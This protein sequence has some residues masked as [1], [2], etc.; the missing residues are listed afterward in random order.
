MR[1]LALPLLLLA[2][3]HAPG[4][5]VPPPARPFPSAPLPPRTTTL[6]TPDQRIAEWLSG[7]KEEMVAMLERVVNQNSGSL[8]R[9]GLAAVREFFAKE[10]RTLGFECEVVPG[11]SMQV[12]RC[13]GR[14]ESLRFGDHLAARR[15]GGAAARGQRVLIVGHMD[16]VFPPDHPFQRFERDLE[17]DTARGPG[18]LDMKGG[19]VILVYALR[20]LAAMGHLDGAR[21][22]VIL[23]ADEEL[24]SL[25]SRR[26]IEAEARRHDVGLVFEGA[27][28]N[29]MVRVRKGLGQ[30]RL[31]VHGRGA[32]AGSAHPDGLSAVRELAYK[33]IEIEKLTD[34][35]AGLTVNVGV[36]QGGD[37]RNTVPP[38]A[39]ALIDIRYVTP[40]QGEAAI[41]RIR[42]IADRSFTR[43]ERH[44]VGTRTEMWHALHRPPKLAT[45]EFDDLLSRVRGIAAALNRDLGVTDSGGGTDGSLT[46]A[47]GLPTLDT[48]G[49]V[50][51]GAHSDRERA[52][53]SL[54]VWRA[55][56][57]AV[58]LYRLTR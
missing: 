41:R 40:E 55:Q 27:P 6:G 32:H 56:L 50:G 48:M 21:I 47:A 58:T 7:R 19:I 25:D 4:R 54:L 33:V 43:N 44:G 49:M 18:V 29:Q 30:V 15:G 45:P 34:Y 22:T 26:L 51:S 37:A 8:N 42:E 46:Q 9:E 52:D 11:G 57:A 23:N 20:A 38:C 14:G 28:D 16:T 53:L 35:S 1:L 10:L 24:G 31:V 13:P 39:E 12:L 5:P 36:V 3:C 17:T 2:G